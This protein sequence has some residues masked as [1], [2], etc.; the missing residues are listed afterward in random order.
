MKNRRA[1]IKAL[2]VSSAG[3]LIGRSSAMTPQTDIQ[4]KVFEVRRACKQF[5][6]QYFH[7]CKNLVEALGEEEAL[8]VVQKTVFELSLDRSDRMRAKALENKLEPTLENFRKVSDLAFIG[9]SGWE[10]S[11]GGVKCPYAEVWLG[12]YDQYPWFKRFASLYCDVI[13]TTNIENFT[14]TTSHR[15]TKN[16]LWGDNECTREYFESAD[17]AAGNFTYGRRV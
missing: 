4:D 7:M 6:M 2:G 15:I 13:D 3:L 1:F 12:Y 11:M 9:W 17:V 8:P 5:A 10:P 16:L 14:R